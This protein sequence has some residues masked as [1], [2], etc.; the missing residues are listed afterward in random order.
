MSMSDESYSAP[1]SSRSASQTSDSV[2]CPHCGTE[3]PSNAAFCPAC[4]WS[5]RPLPAGDRALG[6]L[7]YFTPVPATV[8]LLLPGFR[9][10]RFLRFHAWQSLLIWAV[11]LVLMLIALVLSNV[12]AAVIFLLFAILAALA[13][14]FLW[15]V[16]SIKAWQ[17]ES[18]ELPWFGE[19][20][21]RLR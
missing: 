13:I 6:A 15:I 4:G 3:M 17:G 9:N 20:A 11:F 18:F 10:H 8:L 14:L 5:M 21:S 19:L 16:L 2:V 12:A 7:A 1:S